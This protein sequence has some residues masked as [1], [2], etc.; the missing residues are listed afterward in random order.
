MHLV[1]ITTMYALLLSPEPPDSPFLAM[2][3]TF[4][5]IFASNTSLQFR[6]VP[7]DLLWP[8]WLFQRASCCRRSVQKVL[9]V[10]APLKSEG[11]CKS[12]C[13]STRYEQCLCQH[14]RTS[15][16]L[17]ADFHGST[18]WYGCHPI[19]SNDLLLALLQ[20]GRI[21][22][23]TLRFATTSAQIREAFHFGQF[24][25]CNLQAYW[26]AFARKLIH[27]FGLRKVPAHSTSKLHLCCMNLEVLWKEHLEQT[28]AR[29]GSDQPVYGWLSP[30]SH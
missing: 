23:S 29:F 13:P 26:V 24:G 19:G 1:L 4:L 5:H 9:G 17:Q 8:F 15:T 20:G 16:G 12:R 2:L 30:C 22:R 3:A 28:K 6:P 14:S 21:P 11:Q 18:R 7:F 27:Q 25:H 10:S